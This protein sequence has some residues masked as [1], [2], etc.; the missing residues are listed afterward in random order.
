MYC[1]KCGHEIKEGSNF[2]LECGTKLKKMSSE[3][4]DNKKANSALVSLIIGIISITFGSFLLPLPI[5]GLIIGLKAKEKTGVRK[6][7]IIL[8]LVS[9]LFSILMWFLLIS[10]FYI[11]PIFID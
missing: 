7:G 11:D 3:V 6:T 8:N 5:V 4:N 2:C 10:L 1:E 9:I